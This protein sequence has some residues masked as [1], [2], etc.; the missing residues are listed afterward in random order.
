MINSWH[1]S[2]ICAD[3][4]KKLSTNTNTVHV[5]EEEFQS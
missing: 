2:Q 5:E 4:Y 1:W 3:P